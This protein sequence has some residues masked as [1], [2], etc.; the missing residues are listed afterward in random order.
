MNIYLKDDRIRKAVV[1]IC[2]DTPLEDKQIT[3]AILESL[4]SLETANKSPEP[5]KLPCAS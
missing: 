5:L 3:N 4:F 1:R 2:S